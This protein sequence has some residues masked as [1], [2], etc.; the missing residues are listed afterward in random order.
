LV[1]ASSEL[2]KVLRDRVGPALRQWG[3]AGTAP[4]WNLKTDRGDMAIV[5]VQR[6]NFSPPGQVWFTV[7]LAIIPEPYWRWQQR[8]SLSR[9]PKTPKEENGLWRERLRPNSPAVTAR[10][11]F[12]PWWAVSDVSSA[13][14]AADDVVEGLRERA[15]PELTRL[16]DRR[17]MLALVR[18]P[19]FNFIPLA[20]LLS[21]E[22]PSNELD[23]LLEQMASTGDENVR[24]VYAQAIAW[25]RHN[26]SSRQA[27]TAT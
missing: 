27:R 6:S 18:G 23:S 5:N 25:C 11:R 4:T 13:T 22:G 10:E 17:E 7:N 8:A 14:A 3:F 20:V 2:Q 1:S 19:G 26:A 16:T 9:T 15:I 24:D 12:E 21:D